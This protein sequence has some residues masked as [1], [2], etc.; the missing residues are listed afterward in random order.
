MIDFDGAVFDLDGTIADSHYVWKKV[1]CDFFGKRG[2]RVP[3][4]YNQ[5]IGSMSFRD[6]AIFTKEKYGFSES[7]DEIMKEW[8]SMAIEEYTFNVKPKPFA[9]EYI[10]YIKNHGVKTALCTASP[11]ELFE[12]FLRN[13]Q[14]FSSFDVFV[15]G[16]DVLRDKGFPDIYLL[17]ADKLGVSPEKCIV[18]EDILKAVFGAR[19]AGMR[20][21]GVFEGAVS[22]EERKKIK[23]EA[24]GF[25]YDFSMES[26]EKAGKNLI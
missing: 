23:K 21:I 20:I 25:I 6:A 16:T 8:Y 11:K 13:N 14:M 18:F 24:D 1:D 5:E 15:S 9:G 12:P 7:A 4:N 2:R 22:H 26:L 10:E 3:L 19:A 17:A